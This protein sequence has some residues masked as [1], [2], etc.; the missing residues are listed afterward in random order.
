MPI[1]LSIRCYA[2]GANGV[3]STATPIPIDLGWRT[4]NYTHTI[5]DR[6]GF[7]SMALS[8]KCSLDEVTDW[9]QNGLMR[10]VVVYGPDAQIV[11]EGYLETISASVGQKKAS[12]SL[13]NMANYVRFLWTFAGAVG[14][15][16]PGDTAAT[17]TTA[18][19]LSQSLYGRKDYLGNL[20]KV[21]KTTVDA[22]C[23]KTLATLSFPR[24]AAPTSATTGMLGDITLD[25]TFAGWY[26]TLDWNIVSNSSLTNTATNTQLIATWL[27]SVGATNAF[28]STNYSG[29]TYTG[30]LM[31]EF[32]AHFSTYKQVVEKLLQVGDSSNNTVAYGVYE[33]RV[34]NAVTSAAATPSVVTYRENAGSGQIFDAYGNVVQPWDVR[35]NAMSEIAQ[36]LDV[37]PAT[38]ATDASARKYV[39]RVTCAIQGNS[40]GCTLEPSGAGG[41]DALIAA[42]PAMYWGN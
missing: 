28:L 2:P 39:G 20:P 6:Y 40:I 8:F 35:P 37:S 31:P 4:D 9:L 25:L 32:V 10:S 38:G 36:L 7:E 15:G 21:Y 42:Y 29:I 27:P 23:A 5:S 41:L 12:L 24:S 30:P 18:S 19:L 33:N 1:P 34:F 16:L 11:W 3:P 26:A 17:P 14:N 13:K 22:A